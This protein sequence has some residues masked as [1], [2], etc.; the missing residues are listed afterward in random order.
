MCFQALCFLYWGCC[1][2]STHDKVQGTLGYR[3]KATASGKCPPAAHFPRLSFGS[4]PELS[5]T[6]S[7]MEEAA[8]CKAQNS[9]INTGTRW[10]N[11]TTLLEAFAM[12]MDAAQLTYWGAWEGLQREN[13]PPCEF[14]GGGGQVARPVW[15]SSNLEFLPVHLYLPL[16]DLTFGKLKRRKQHWRSP[17][18]LQTA[19]SQSSCRQRYPR[20]GP[21]RA[22]P[23]RSCGRL[24]AEA[25]RAG[26]AARCP[27]LCHRSDAT[28][29]SGT[30]HGPASPLPSL[31]FGKKITFDRPVTT[32]KLPPPE[33]PAAEARRPPHPPPPAN[34]PHRPARR[35][36]SPARSAP[37]QHT[38]QREARTPPSPPPSASLPA[39]WR[40]PRARAVPAAEA[41]GPSRALPRPAGAAAT[42]PPG[43]VVRERGA[44]LPLRK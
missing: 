11:R 4:C 25:A 29:R 44:P 35:R 22:L 33:E 42:A 5:K 21:A 2:F 19:L 7:C 6:G 30:N 40:R 34:S 17:L 3:Y 9:M 27:A 41:A 28:L 31:S 10:Q 12:E 20:P 15:G 38:G 39:S 26:Q 13:R 24:T 14:R 18:R 8:R 37:R 32:G 43:D 1:S 36:V 23:S 16:L